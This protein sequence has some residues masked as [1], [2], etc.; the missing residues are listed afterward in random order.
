MCGIAFLEGKDSEITV[1]KMLDMLRHRGPDDVGTAI[2]AGG[3]TVG[4]CRLS[5]IDP[6]GGRQPFQAGD[7][8][9]TLAA[10][11]MIYNYRALQ[12]ELTDSAGARFESH[13][14]S[15]V[16]LHAYRRSGTN[17]VAELDGMFAFVRQDGERILAAR[18]RVGIKPLYMGRI[19]GRLCFASEIKALAGRAERI[20]E[21]PPGHFYDSREGF[22]RYYEVPVPSN[23]LTEPDD[24]VRALRTGL[25]AAVEKRLQSDV[26]LG[27][28][29]SGGL[30]S[31]LIAAIAR[32][33]LDR[34]HTFAV[35]FPDSPDLLAARRVAEYL[36]TD[37][38]EHIL[39][40]DEVLAALPEILY[41]LE[42]FDADLVR[43][44][45]PC[46]F[47]S[48]LAAERVKVVLTGEGADELFAGYDY[49]KALGTGP[50]L[51]TELRRSIGA[52]HNINLQRVDRMTMAH[53]LEARVPFLDTA[54]IALAARIAPDLKMRSHKDGGA[55]EKWIL[56]RAFSDL[57]PDDI[58]WRDKLQFDQGSGAGD[59]LADATAAPAP[60]SVADI[61]L[62]GADQAGGPRTLEEKRYRDIMAS[63]LP[64][65]EQV[66]PL[67][68]HW[69]AGQPATGEAA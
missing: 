6:A 18:D 38:H 28:F 58:V 34:L 41:H 40:E 57:L 35:G 55:T 9:I 4:H 22:V 68:A 19:D 24:A 63:V 27:A 10:N 32:S 48:K 7:G 45:V 54:M 39:D 15:E 16:I 61:R 11:G 53:G 14:D 52:L 43:S 33:R 3:G 46:W 1:S 51:Q 62:D 67:V 47:V 23:D 49:H 64:A 44:A 13:S 17:A 20:E 56:R 12:R 66:F 2:T 30:D 69:S 8:R 65:A 29:L 60:E 42:S 21:F 26:P 31:S 25:E 50:A 5:I 37:H 36:D 59:F